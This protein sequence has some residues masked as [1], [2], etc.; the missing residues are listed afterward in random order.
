[1]WRPVGVVGA[2]LAAMEQLV[3]G[4][5][6]LLSAVASEAGTDEGLGGNELD[7]VRRR[8]IYLVRFVAPVAEL[9]GWPANPPARLTAF[10]QVHLRL[11]GVWRT[12]DDLLDSTPGDDRRQLLVGR[13]VASSARAAA[14]MAQLGLGPE[15]LERAIAITCQARREE[16]REGLPV[17]RIPER[18]APFLVV[19]RVLLT[20][21]AF[22][23]WQA[24]LAAVGLLH[25]VHDVARDL[26]Q[27]IRTLPTTWLAEVSAAREFRPDVFSTWW[28]RCAGEL[29]RA[30]ERVPRET[31]GPITS[32]LLDEASG[33]AAEMRPPVSRQT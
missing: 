24:Y 4:V 15:S 5:R 7:R 29:T 2:L 33:F 11:A 13:S 27:G 12:L 25:D 26:E 1:M 21:Q 6:Q 14:A 23:A 16:C 8:D 32:L 20:P 31:I 28:V 10:L 3:P 17:E 9:A 30:I 18:A 19:P 22:G